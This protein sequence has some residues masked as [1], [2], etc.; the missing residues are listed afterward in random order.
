MIVPVI[1]W[2]E[3]NNSMGEAFRSA[4]ELLE[5]RIR[6]RGSMLSVLVGP[7]LLIFIGTSIGMLVIA[8]MMPLVSLIQYLT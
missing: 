2:G 1:Q 4:Y 8:M 3:N 5:G 6:L 7:L